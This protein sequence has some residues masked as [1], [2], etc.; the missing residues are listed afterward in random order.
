MAQVG[1]FDYDTPLAD[2]HFD[3]NRTWHGSYT[4]SV[5]GVWAVH[6]DTTT[7]LSVACGALVTTTVTTHGDGRDHGRVGHGTGAGAGPET[8]PA[9]PH[10]L[11]HTVPS[12]TVLIEH[13][14]SVRSFDFRVVCEA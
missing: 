3:G 6:V 1:R 2:V 14:H 9:V 12:A 7:A 11:R 10:V 13:P 4:A 8:A 5:A